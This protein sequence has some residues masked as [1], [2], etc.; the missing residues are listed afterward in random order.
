MKAKTDGIVAASYPQSFSDYAMEVDARR[1]AGPAHGSYGLLFRHEPTA[2]YPAITSYYYLWIKPADGTYGL[3]KRQNGGWT[4]LQ[5]TT[6]SSYIQRDD[7]T[8]RIRVEA[9]G[10]EITVYVNGMYLMRVQNGSL[11]TGWIGLTASGNGMHVHFDNVLVWPA[12]ATGIHGRVRYNGAAS[13]GIELR[14]RYFNGSSW[15]TA[16]TTTTDCAGRYVFTGAASLGAGQKYYVR[17][18]PNSTVPNYVS[19]WYGPD[20]MSY[21]AGTRLYGGDFDLANVNLI[22]PTSGAGVTLPATF[23][24]QRRG[25]ATDTYRWYLFD[26]GS[27]DAWITNDLGYAGSFTLTGLPGGAQTGKEYGWYVRVYRGSYSFGKSFYYRRITFLS[28]GTSS[29][30]GSVVP[31]PADEGHGPPEQVSPNR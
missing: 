28:S 14:L 15:S 27:S 21:T 7:A 22:A 2:N 24:W 1:V 26:P 13:E 17:Y 16:A 31:L 29:P 9:V 11:T 6:A 30:G 23:N 19:N 8:N 4:T 3:L 10:S 20:L 5:G 25:I 18:G 12:P